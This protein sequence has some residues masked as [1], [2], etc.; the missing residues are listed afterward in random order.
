MIEGWCF[1]PPTLYK[2]FGCPRQ[3]LRE[4]L[5]PERFKDDFGDSAD[6]RFQ[7]VLA[8]IRSRV[9]KGK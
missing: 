9:R 4:G 1:S 3:Y 7:K 5:S 8:D 6:P 2:V